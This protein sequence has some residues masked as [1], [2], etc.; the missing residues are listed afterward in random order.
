MS[1]VQREREREFTYDPS[2]LR[3]WSMAST[4]TSSSTPV[5]KKSLAERYVPDRFY[6]GFQYRSHGSD[7]KYLSP[8]GRRRKGIPEDFK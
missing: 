8:E 1:T 7:P 4:S 6:R 2:L 5:K 3:T